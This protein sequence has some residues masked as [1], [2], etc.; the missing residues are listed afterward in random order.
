MMVQRNFLFVSYNGVSIDLAWQILKEG[1]N[2]KYFIEY[3]EEKDVGD[4]FVPKVDDWKKEIDW[5]DVIIFDEIS[6]MGEIASKLR[7]E[8]KLVIG[9]T[10]YT[11]L[12]E[13]DRAFGQEEMKKHN[14]SI[15]PYNIFTSI[16]EAITFVQNNPSRYVIK[17]SGKIQSNKDL[18]FVGEEEDGKDVLQILN[19]YKK[20]YS[21]K[22]KEIQLQKRIFGV[23]VA[24]GAFFNG[25]EFIYPIN[26]NFEYKKLFPG[27]LGPSTGEMGTMMFWSK[28]NKLFNETLKKI[29]PKLKKEGY[30]GYIDLN[31]I[32][33]A[34]GIY[35]LEW[36]TR[37]GYPTISIQQD[38]MITPIGEFLYKLASGQN[39][40]LKV[41]SGFHIGVLIVVPPFPFNDNEIFNL[42]SKELVINTKKDDIAQY[43]EGIHIEDVRIVNEKWVVASNTGSILV[44][45][46]SGNTISEAQKQTYFRINKLMIPRMY[47][48][49]DIGDRWNEDSDKLLNWGYLRGE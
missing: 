12:L 13:D 9:G 33:N 17:P 23:E 46:G 32:V 7:N 4:G 35:P 19:D 44:V 38:S 16:D 24:V 14:I 18:L 25:K 15:I 27:N 37:F 29:E 49:N 31:C 39:F 21:S 8:G 1:N 22:I 2:V 28:P 36:T 26:V 41:K 42:Y 3:P 43:N 40:E 6:G 11:D 20:F 5:A 48:R 10:P 30:I 34:N 45:C 47:Y